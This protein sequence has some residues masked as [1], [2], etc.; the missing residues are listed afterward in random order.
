MANGTTTQGWDLDSPEFRGLFTRE[1]VM[2][3][4][5]YAERL[6]AKQSAALKRATA[7]LAAIELFVS[8]PGNEEPTAR[9]GMPTRVEAAKA[10]V[11]RF[12]SAEFREQILGTVG[13]QA[14]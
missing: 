11:A 3:S 8:T 2:E 4:D 9:L 14:F 1:S 6:D 5:W 10:E 7:G 12:S 13:G